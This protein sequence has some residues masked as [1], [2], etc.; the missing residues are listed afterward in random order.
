[1]FCEKHYAVK[2]LQNVVVNIDT[3][4]PRWGMV[5][6]QD[7]SEPAGIACSYSVS[8]MS[9]TSHLKGPSCL[10]QKHYKIFFYPKKSK[11]QLQCSNVRQSK[12]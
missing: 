6:S 3:V 2:T 10:E 11:L 4:V 7:S 5:S 9:L 1:M 8:D 12:C